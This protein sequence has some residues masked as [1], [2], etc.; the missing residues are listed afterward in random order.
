MDSIKKFREL[1]GLSRIELAQL[2]GVNVETIARYERGDREPRISVLN[3][4][5]NVLACTPNELLGV[6]EK[7]GE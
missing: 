6:E 7:E 1:R 2:S 3:T 4:I 5:A